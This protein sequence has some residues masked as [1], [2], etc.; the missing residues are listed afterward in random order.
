MDTLTIA[1]GMDFRGVNGGWIECNDCFAKRRNHDYDTRLELTAA[2]CTRKYGQ[3]RCDACGKMLTDEPVEIGEF[4]RI[5]AWKTEGM[6]IDRRRP[7][8]PLG[9]VQ[10]IEVLVEVRIDDPKPRWYRLEPNEYEVL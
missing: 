10:A 8:L 1:H 9:T 5:P 6:V 2:D 4:I 7:T 3:S